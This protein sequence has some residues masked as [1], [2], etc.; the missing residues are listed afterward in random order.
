MDSTEQCPEEDLDSSYNGKKKRF[1]RDGVGTPSC[2][3]LTHGKV[4]NQATNVDNAN[5]NTLA[6]INTNNIGDNPIV[7]LSSNIAT[8]DGKIDNQNNG[9][10]DAFSSNLDILNT[11]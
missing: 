8:P 4:D 2:D 7:G 11:L 9:F 5:P 1:D 6:G 10:A 3:Y